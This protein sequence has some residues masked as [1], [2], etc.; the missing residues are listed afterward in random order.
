MATIFR[1]K[2]VTT[3]LQK[4]IMCVFIALGTLS[5]ILVTCCL[6]LLKVNKICDLHMLSFEIYNTAFVLKLLKLSLGHSLNFFFI[7]KVCVGMPPE[8]C[9]CLVTAV[10][11][12]KG[13]HIDC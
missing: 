11:Q 9:S 13:E 8:K 10:K 2:V 4:T 5:L 1:I 12:R 3:R 7:K 6:S